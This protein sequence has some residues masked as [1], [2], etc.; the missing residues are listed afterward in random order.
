M[1]SQKFF[2]RKQAQWK[3]NH[4]SK[5]MR[6]GEKGKAKKIPKIVKPKDVG[7]FLVQKLSQNF[8]YVHALVTMH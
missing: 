8:D 1:L 5:N 7:H 3:V 2:N 6:K 4:C